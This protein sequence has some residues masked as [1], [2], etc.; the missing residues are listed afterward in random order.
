MLMNS[1]V[2]RDKTNIKTEFNFLSFIGGTKTLD[3]KDCDNTYVL[4]TDDHCM[5]PLPST[6]HR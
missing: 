2:G 6:S 1:I 4:F 3:C 5:A